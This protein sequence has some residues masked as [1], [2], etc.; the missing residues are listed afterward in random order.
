MAVEDQVMTGVNSM[1]DFIKNQV[2]LRLHEANNKKIIQLE[3]EML[4]RVGS[5]VENTIQNAFI[6]SSE[7]VIS[8]LKNLKEK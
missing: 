3:E 7:E 5:V 8:K 6:L 2:K 4:D 1:I